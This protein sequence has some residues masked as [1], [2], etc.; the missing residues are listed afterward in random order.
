[1][2][3]L[4]FKAPEWNEGKSK[5][6]LS[7]GSCKINETKNKFLVKYFTTEIK[8]SNDFAGSLPLKNKS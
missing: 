4:V 5:F 3:T 1:M 8:C 6:K 2:E 7:N